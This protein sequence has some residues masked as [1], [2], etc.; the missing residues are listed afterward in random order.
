MDA[1]NHH[2]YVRRLQLISRDDKGQPVAN[3]LTIVSESGLSGYEVFRESCRILKEL[4]TSSSFAYQFTNQGEGTIRY[5]IHDKGHTFGSVFQDLVFDDKDE[6]GVTSIG[7]FQ[8]HPLD[9]NIVV[10]VMPSNPTTDADHLM[11]S[12]KTRCVRRLEE[13]MAELS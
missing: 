6:L 9:P 3:T 7:Y 10:C 5:T 4:F 12:M 8:P 13:K 2:D 11:S 1:L